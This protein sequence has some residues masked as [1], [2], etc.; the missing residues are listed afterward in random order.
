MDKI[1]IIKKRKLMQTIDIHT[2]LLSSEVKF[3]HFYDK[4]YV[5]FLLRSWRGRL[6]DGGSK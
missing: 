5:R 2:H 3:D 6:S 4:L 1:D